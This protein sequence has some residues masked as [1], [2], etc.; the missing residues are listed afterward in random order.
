VIRL[1]QGGTEHDLLAIEAGSL[2]PTVDWVRAYAMATTATFTHLFDVWDREGPDAANRMTVAEATAMLTR[3]M[4]TTDG[5]IC[6][7]CSGH[8]VARKRTINEPVASFV[9]WLVRRYTGSPI[10]AGAWKE[11]NPT[12]AR[13]GT[14]ARAKHWQLATREPGQAPLW[15][16]TEHGKR[17]AWGMVEVHQ[18]AVLHRNRVLRFEGGTVSIDAVLPGSS[19]DHK[20]GIGRTPE[21]PGLGA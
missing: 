15:S 16:P 6:P 11:A 2:R 18:H 3:L 17:W 10:H 4:L 13:G 19:D 12:L 5:A 21:L 7:C 20:R 1:V 14:Y 9:T 8:V